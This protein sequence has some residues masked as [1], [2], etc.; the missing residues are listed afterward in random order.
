MNWEYYTLCATFL[1]HICVPRD[2]VYFVCAHGA[3]LVPWCQVVLCVTAALKVRD[4][5]L[6]VRSDHGCIVHTAGSFP[7]AAGAPLCRVAEERNNWYRLSRAV[8]ILLATDQPIAAS[9]P[10]GGQALADLDYDFRPFF[11]TRPRLEV[12]ARVDERVE[13]MVRT[14]IHQSMLMAL[15][16]VFS[17][18]C[19]R[20]EH[21]VR[22]LKSSER[23]GLFALCVAH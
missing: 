9:R 8:E 12:F 23:S 13:R 15:A 20:M 2:G 22:A 1:L 4:A 7:H 14:C 10:D 17:R 5:K 21:V 16:L 19:K 18:V 3:S 11:L 6:H